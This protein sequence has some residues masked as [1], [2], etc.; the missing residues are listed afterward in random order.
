MAMLEWA[1]VS[2][3][4]V[5]SSAIQSQRMYEV[6]RSYSMHVLYAC[7][8][9]I[10][11][12]DSCMSSPGAHL[13]AGRDTQGL[14]IDHASC[15]DGFLQKLCNYMCCLRRPPRLYRWGCHGTEIYMEVNSALTLSSV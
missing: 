2:C 12:S 13:P 6:M 14:Q 10:V 9:L 4:K 3:S 5:L 11:T 7:M 8:K 1:D 15:F